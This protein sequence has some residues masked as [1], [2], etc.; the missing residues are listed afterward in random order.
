MWPDLKV[1]IMSLITWRIYF[2][3]R[4][5]LIEIYLSISRENLEDAIKTLLFGYYVSL[6]SGLSELA[7]AFD[8]IRVIEF[9]PFGW[10]VAYYWV[11]RG[12]DTLPNPA[13]FPCKWSGDA[14]EAPVPL[15]SRLVSSS[16]RSLSHLIVIRIDCTSCWSSGLFSPLLVS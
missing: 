4:V 3:S 16:I 15:S 8:Y 6:V 1:N 14:D 10:L 9:R 13:P 11:R 7:V 2:T 5:S 12:R